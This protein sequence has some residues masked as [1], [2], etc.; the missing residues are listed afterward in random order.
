MAD[1]GESACVE[2]H[3]TGAQSIDDGTVIVRVVL[4]GLPRLYSCC[5]AT[6]VHDALLLSSPESAAMRFT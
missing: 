6:A 2:W 4:V 3:P 1:V 5:F